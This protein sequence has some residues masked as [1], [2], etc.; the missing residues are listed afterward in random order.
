MLTMNKLFQKCWELTLLSR[1]NNKNNNNNNKNPH[2]SFHQ[3]LCNYVWGGA[4][5]YVW[6]V[7]PQPHTHKKHSLLLEEN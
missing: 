3:G 4:P 2:A 6:G 5:H 1:G 7:T